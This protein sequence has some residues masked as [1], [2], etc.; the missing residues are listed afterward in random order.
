MHIILFLKG[1]LIALIISLPL[2]PVGIL[3]IRRTFLEGFVAGMATTLGIALADL[4]FATVTVLGLTMVKDHIQAHKNLLTFLGGLIIL[5]FGFILLKSDI[6]QPKKADED[7]SLVGEVITALLLTLSNP[8][9][10]LGFF[11]LFSFLNAITDYHGIDDILI[12]IG[13]FM[14][15]TVWFGLLTVIA[16]VLKKRFNMENLRWLN[17]MMGLLTISFGIFM[18]LKTLKSFLLR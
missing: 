11:A 2:G 5:V 4:V 17:K 1:F 6:K 12:L 18:I 10:L 16:T 9:T 8:L 14:G 13:V 3:C 15:T 7:R